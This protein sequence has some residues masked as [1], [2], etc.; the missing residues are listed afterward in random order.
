MVG[1]KIVTMALPYDQ[2]W[3]PFPEFNILALA[4]HLDA[5]GRARAL[6]EFMIQWRR[7]ALPPPPRN[8]RVATVECL[9]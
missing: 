7:S 3:L 4:P 2:D 1:P 9:S 6:D 8:N 5:A